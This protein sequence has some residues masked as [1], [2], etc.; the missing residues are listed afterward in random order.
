MN[1]LTTARIT[2]LVLVIGLFFGCASNQPSFS[3]LKEGGLYEEALQQIN[4]AL[5]E[6]PDDAVLHLEKA[7][8]LGEWAQTKKAQSREPDYQEMVNSI[9]NALNVFSDPDIRTV[10]DSLQ[11]HYWMLEHDAGIAL[12]SPQSESKN[13]DQAL[14]HFS[15]AL[16]IDSGKASTYRSKAVAQYQLGYMEDAL[17]TLQTAIAIVES[18]P[19]NLY[20]DIGLLYLESGNID[21]AILNYEQAGIDIVTNKKIAYKIINHYL[22]TG[23]REKATELLEVLANE[24]PNNPDIRNVYGTELYRTTSNIISELKEAYQQNDSVLVG[25]LRL[26]IEGNAE[27]AEE[28]LSLAFSSDST[29]VNYVE[30]IAVFYNNLSAEYMAL[31]EVAF[32]NHIP[33]FTDKANTLGALSIRYYQQLASLK[34][35]DQ[36]VLRKLTTLRRLFAEQ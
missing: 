23:E 13:L 28:N 10:S 25:Q 30:S 12:S 35:S 19:L 31:S 17:N 15:N 1:S 4:T 24:Y 32:E 20:E 26:E 29:N 11:A 5:E 14:V 3:E 18:P 27:L 21:E 8:L 7:K 2:S 34:P 16:T 36:Q 33:L 6:N 9:G 22:S